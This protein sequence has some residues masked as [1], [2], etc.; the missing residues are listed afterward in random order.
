MPRQGYYARDIR[1]ANDGSSFQETTLRLFLA[2]LFATCL[3]G[4]AASDKAILDR[5]A[6]ADDKEVT[7]RNLAACK[8]QAEAAKLSAESA[9]YTGYMN[10]CLRKAAV[11]R[12]PR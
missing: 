12:S 2:T 5:G 7:A 4:C 1:S 11:V 10:D 6:T 3:Y 8:A 9:S